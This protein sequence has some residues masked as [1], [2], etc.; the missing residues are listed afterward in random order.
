MY[1]NIKRCNLAAVA[2]YAAMNNT[3]RNDA[4][5]YCS[6]LN[7]RMFEYC[8]VQLN[9][10]S[11]CVILSLYNLFYISAT[12]MSI[13]VDK[14]EHTYVKKFIAAIFRSLFCVSGEFCADVRAA[15]CY[16]LRWCQK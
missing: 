16:F 6:V 13:L 3:K 8:L 9:I 15:Q 4:R 5:L 1:V 7:C 11:F 14:N 10:P 2:A 12:K